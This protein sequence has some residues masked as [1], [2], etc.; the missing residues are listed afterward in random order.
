M[1]EQMRVSELAELLGVSKS[2][3]RRWLSRGE[4]PAHTRTPGG[5]YIFH[6]P[7]AL[8]QWINSLRAGTS[9]DDPNSQD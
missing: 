7:N 3:V 6:D 4:G 5:T 9:A 2:S 8:R 1:A